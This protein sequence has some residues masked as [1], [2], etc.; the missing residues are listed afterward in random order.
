[1]K[2]IANR[3]TPHALQSTATAAAASPNSA[4]AAAAAAAAINLAS[5]SLD[6]VA[7]SQS[8]NGDVQPQLITR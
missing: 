2:Q 7:Y 6:Y 1:M 8:P 5:S 4:A 3:N